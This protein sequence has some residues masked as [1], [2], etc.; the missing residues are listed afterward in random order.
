[1]PRVSAGTTLTQIEHILC[2]GTGTLDFAIEG[3]EQYYTWEGEEDADW[4]VSNVERIQNED[5]DRIIIWPDEGYFS[6]E[7][8][9]DADGREAVNCK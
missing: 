8:T 1:M 4:T 7:I 6:C 9:L 5:E 3:E 2:S